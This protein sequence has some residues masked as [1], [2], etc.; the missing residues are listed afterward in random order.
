[1]RIRTRRVR[2]IVAVVTL[3]IGTIGSAVGLAAGTAAAVTPLAGSVSAIST[4]TITSTAATQAAGNLTITLTTVTS[5]T[6][7]LSVAPASGTV[8]WSAAPV[9]VSTATAT[10]TAGTLTGSTFNITFSKATPGAETITVSTIKY[11]A[12][13]ALGTVTVTASATGYAF[14][15]ATAVNATITTKGATIAATADLNIASTGTNQDAGGLKITL[16]AT[17]TPGT[18]HL[19][20]AATSGSVA[21]SAPPSAV[22]TTGTAT[23]VATTGATVTISFATTATTTETISVTTVV[24]TTTSATGTVTVTPSATGYIFTPATVA[25]A[26][27]VTA[28]ATPSFSLHATGTPDV[29]VGVT[30]QAAGTWTLAFSGTSTTSNGWTA[31]EAVTVTVNDHA[32]HNCATTAAILLTGT[33]TASVTTSSGVSTAPTVTVSVKNTGTNCASTTEHNTVTVTLTNS[34]VFNTPVGGSFDIAVST[35]RYNVGST[36]TLGNV[37]VTGKFG[38]TTQ[39]PSTTGSPGGPSNADVVTI[40]VTANT[41]PVKATPTALDVPISPVKITESAPGA[42]PAGTVCLTLS[43]GSF[44]AT[45]N[46]TAKVTTG[47]AALTSPTVAYTGATASFTVKTPSSATASTFTV[48]GLAVDAPSSSG[49]VR[50]T[51][52]DATCATVVGTAV[53]YTVLKPVNRI[54]GATADATAAQE[55]ARTFPPSSDPYSA[56][57]PGTSVFDIVTGQVKSA[58]RP[59]VL[60]RD[61]AF[62]D[63]LSSQYLA[64]YLQTGTLLTPQ[65]ALSAVTAA[66]IR[67]EGITHVY[68]VG[69]P[70]AVSTTV[71]KQIESTPVYVC[72]G[73]TELLLTGKPVDIQVTR[74]FGQTEYG[75]SQAVAR[76]PSLSITYGFSFPSAYTG[77]N[78]TGGHGQFND[79]AGAASTHA[80]TSATL[81][82]AIVST[83]KGFQDAESASVLAY[84]AGMPILLT[85]PANLSSNAKA[86]IATLKVKQVVLMGG[87]FAV[88]NNVV[89]QLQS[90]GISVLRIAGTSA[91]GTAVQLAD[92]EGAGYPTG[93]WDQYLT[94]TGNYFYPQGTV[95]VARGDFYSDGLAGAVVAAHAEYGCSASYTFTY[96]TFYYGAH[97]RTALGYTYCDA[98][99]A[100]MLLTVNPSTVGPALTTF[101]TGAGANGTGIDTNGSEVITSINVLGGPFAVTPSTAQQ[102]E[103]DLGH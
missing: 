57:C 23:V 21:W 5:G 16:P 35:V 24:Y 14:T 63:A 22:A 60:A 78:T 72:G 93:L 20:L 98:D 45:A 28:P 76:F 3:G 89:S 51:V 70:G 8:S 18:L 95:T 9:V 80:A 25:N 7:S 77:V 91:T 49:A 92:F 96:G 88:S 94:A 36:A 73:K 65:G 27:S 44:D 11:T 61:N 101:L 56:S 47:D 10:A 68:L 43:A 100:P 64:G 13:R 15:P 31:G 55:L 83:G 79:T 34:G 29:R 86:A 71:V 67:Q 84:A 41:P 30:D 59:V 32:G 99:A 85:T 1:L 50:V 46:A 52:K 4:T 81:V 17:A 53:A 90:L 40:A 19:H 66:A 75:T 42:V 26:T 12:T 69:G 39:G 38:T 87:Q 58:D 2:R 48:S 102:M 74:I 103:T 37:Q 62:P 82:T 54:Y 33:P 6:L 97:N